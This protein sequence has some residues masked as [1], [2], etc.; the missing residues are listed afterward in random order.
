MFSYGIK[1]PP[2]NELSLEKFYRC[3]KILMLIFNDE[4]VGKITLGDGTHFPPR[5]N[6]MKLVFKKIEVQEQ[7]NLSLNAGDLDA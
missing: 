2:E 1:K 3:A 6:E 5:N 7:E 4:Q